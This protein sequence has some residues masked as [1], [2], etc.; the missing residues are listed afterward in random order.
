[1][2]ITLI[3]KKI[4][5]AP[6]KTGKMFQTAE[7]AFKN[8]TYGGKVEGKKIT[9]YSKAWKA[10]A[11]ANVGETFEVET[12]KNGQYVEWVSLSKAGVP[13]GAV[14]QHKAEAKVGVAN[15]VKSSYETAEERAKRQVYIVRQSSVA[16]AIATLSVGAKA[17]K[18]DEVIALAQKYEGYVFGT[19]DSGFDDMTNDIPE[20]P[21][22]D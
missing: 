19:G 14:G 15:P 1:M 18:P 20:G 12:E 11:E 21:Q 5:T 7:L 16:N 13:G 6:N 3:D 9:E 17:V 8:N 10:V 22:V 2:N 4:T